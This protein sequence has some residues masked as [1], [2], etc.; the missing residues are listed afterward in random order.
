MIYNVLFLL[1]Q[2]VDWVWAYTAAYGKGALIRP[3]DQ[4]PLESLQLATSSAC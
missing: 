3:H 4:P 1:T 2:W